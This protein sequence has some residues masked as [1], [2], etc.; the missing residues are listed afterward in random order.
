MNITNSDHE[1]M[2]S[3]SLNIFGDFLP[4]Q[5]LPTTYDQAIEF[6]RDIA[7]FAAD[8]SAPIEVHLTPISGNVCHREFG[9]IKQ[10][11]NLLRYLHWRGQNAQ[12]HV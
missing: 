2:E 5:P 10:L 6:Y 12:R 7:L 8:S 4:T 11:I 1:Y 9:L 3:V